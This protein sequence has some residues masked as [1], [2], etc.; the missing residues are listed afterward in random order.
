MTPLAV[1]SGI[2][3]VEGITFEWSE[4]ENLEA[5][6]LCLDLGI[7]PNAADDEGRT[8]LHGAAHQGR[9]VVVQLLVD[10]GAKL[11]AC[12]A[13]WQSVGRSP[14]F[15]AQPTENRNVHSSSLSI[16]NVLRQ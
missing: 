5:V 16:A 1:A 4:P 3:W 2:G 11:D 14:R 13:Q 7:D 15:C 8:A 6:N 9:N 10:R 12:D